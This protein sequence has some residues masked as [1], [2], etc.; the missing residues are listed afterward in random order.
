MINEEIYYYYILN[1]SEVTSRIFRKS[2]QTDPTTVRHSL[3]GSK[4]LL[5]F[6]HHDL[7]FEVM[8]LALSGPHSSPEMRQYIK[9]NAAAWEASE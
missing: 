7:P 4:V 9:D 3:D 2:R 5:S 8:S 1:C 6:C